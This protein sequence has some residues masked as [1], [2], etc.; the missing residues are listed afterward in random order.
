MPRR[1]G[2][3]SAAGATPGL[4]GRGRG[5]ANTHAD[6]VGPAGKAGLPLATTRLGSKTSPRG[7]FFLTEARESRKQES[8]ADSREWRKASIGLRQWPIGLR[9][10]NRLAQA[11]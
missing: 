2:L 8:G 10:A 7:T 3:L 11:G 5:A 9:R 6:S 4:V 1:P